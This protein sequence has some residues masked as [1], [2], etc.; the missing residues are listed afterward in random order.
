MKTNL[1]KIVEGFG[2]RN[3]CYVLSNSVTL[4]VL[5]SNGC[6]V[7]HG[8]I[9]DSKHLELNNLAPQVSRLAAWNKLYEMAKVA[10]I[11]WTK[12]SSM[13]DYGITEQEK[14]GYP[15]LYTEFEEKACGKD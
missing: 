4:D 14:L 1:F 9:N 7:V 8:P 5:Y 6:N 11:K 10:G 15:Y 13:L 3:F 2:E 12:R